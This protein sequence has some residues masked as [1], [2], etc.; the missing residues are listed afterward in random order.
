MGCQNADMTAKRDVYELLFGPSYAL[1]V[2]SLAIGGAISV[3][4]AS[5]FA[6]GYVLFLLS[7]VWLIGHWIIAE[8]V[9]ERRRLLRVFV[10]NLSTWRRKGTT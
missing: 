9:K 3:A 7:G 10:R 8:P 2:I 5:Q 1:V 4:L 6:L